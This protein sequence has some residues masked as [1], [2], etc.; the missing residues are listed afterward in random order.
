MNTILHSRHMV[1]CLSVLCILSACSSDNG[2]GVEAQ[3]QASAGGDINA[4]TGQVVTLNGSGSRD[5]GGNPFDFSWK[6]IEKPATST[7]ILANS[8][9]E[10][11]TFTP[12]VQGKYKIELT[13]SNTLES[14][15]TVTVSAFKVK[16]VLGDYTNITPGPN[17][18]IRD[19]ATV[20]D[21]LY[22]TCEFTEIGGIE[23]NKIAAY[24]GANWFALGCGLED[25]SIY[26]MIDY[27][28]ELY[29]TGQFDEIGCIAAHNIARWNGW[30]WRPVEGGLTGGDGP[31]GHALSIYNGALYVG[32][33]FTKAG[34]VDVSNI[35]KWD[36]SNWSAVGRFE[37][38][39]VRALQ[40]YKQKLYA[41][42]F[43]TKVNSANAEF[44]AAYDGTNW[45]NLGSRNVLE[46]KSTGTVKHMAVYK[47]LLYISGNFSTNTDDVSELINYNGT[48][49]SDF[50]SAFSLYPGNL[51]E[52]LSVINGILYIG[53]EFKNVVASQANNILQWDGD[54]WGILG[55]GTSGTVLAIEPYKNKIYIGGDFEEA[56]GNPAEKISIWKEN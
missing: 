18:G 15:D 11:P 8:D 3:L 36:G 44:I 16:I 1:P 39:S 33:S 2:G 26:D 29:V 20:C 9:G 41:G 21:T 7:A 17:V 37:G 12:D 10:S 35:A 51:I 49:F 14:L 19:F 43:F 48:Q 46:L 52:E 34:D 32:G 50:G 23:A 54:T 31:Y 28:C 53:G 40:V 47:D 55:E 4:K 13:I 38:G 56:G 45:T 27:N 42:G 22:A 5:S 24:D 30:I 25:G 6:F